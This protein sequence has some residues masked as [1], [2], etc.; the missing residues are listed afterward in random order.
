M[1]VTDSH[2][3]FWGVGLKEDDSKILNESNWEGLNLLG[4]CLNKLIEQYD[5]L[6]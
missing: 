2:I 5:R 1:K 6:Q 4:K 3:Y